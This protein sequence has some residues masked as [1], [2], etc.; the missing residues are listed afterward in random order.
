MTQVSSELSTIDISA[1]AE[2]ARPPA[3]LGSITAAVVG[4]SLLDG[5]AQANNETHGVGEFVNEK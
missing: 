5:E 2:N 1:A 4:S 3:D